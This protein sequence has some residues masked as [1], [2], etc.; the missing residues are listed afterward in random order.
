MKEYLLKAKFQF[1]FFFLYAL[2]SNLFCKDIYEEAINDNIIQKQIIQEDSKNDIIDY[3]L[4]PGKVYNLKLYKLKTANIRFLNIKNGDNYVIHFYPLECKIYLTD[5]NDNIDN[6]YKISNYDYDAFY[7]LITGNRTFKVKPLINLI[8]EEINNIT[9]PLIINSVK[10][11]NNSQIPELILNEKEPVLFFFKDKIT[12]L[13]LIYNHNKSENPIIIS[14]F[15]KEKARFRIEC[16][17]GKEKI[18]KI[19]YYKETLLIKPNS[20]N[21]QYNILITRI[22]QVNSTMIIKISGNNSSS[23]YL[24]N[25]ILNL[26]LI[27]KNELCQYYYMKI[28]KGQE[29]EIILNNKRLNG[30]L[31]SK[32]INKNDA[33]IIPNSELFPEC[34]KNI[35][36]PKE[37]LQYDEY[38]KI[39]SF[40]S[41]NTK[42]CEVNCYLL[43]TYYSEQHNYLNITGNEYTLL[44][45]VWDEEDFIS[46]V[47]NIP[48][49]EFIF[50]L[51][52]D[53]TINVHYYCVYIP[54]ETDNI[55]VE[56]FGENI[57]SYAKKGI[58]K[59]NVFKT[60][61]NTIQLNKK[62][63]EKLIINLNKKDLGLNSFKGQYI[64]LAFKR[65][66]N[67]NKFSYYHFRI[68]QPNNNNIIIYPVDTNKDGLCETKKIDGNNSCFFL[69][70]NEYQELSNNIVFFGQGQDEVSSVIY[71]LNISDDYSIELEN[72]ELNKN[73]ERAYG[74]IKYEGG[75]EDSKFALIK[76]MSNYYENITFV[77]N[78]FHIN[79]LN[80]IF[81]IYSYQL[82]FLEDNTKITFNIN[83]NISNKYRV[84]INNIG[85][86]GYLKSNDTD[87]N[88]DNINLEGRKEIY[89]F[90]FY[91]E[92]QIRNISL[93]SKRNLAFITKM[94][95][96]ITYDFM[97]ELDCQYNKRVIVNKVNKDK[98][99]IIYYIKDI[100][101]EGMD[102][103]IHFTFQNDSVNNNDFIIK[104]GFIDYHVFNDIENKDDVAHYLHSSFYGI[105]DP[106]IN[107]GLIV[108]DKEFSEENKN[109]EIINK[110]NDEYSF[111]L[112]DKNKN[113]NN[114]IN[115]FAYEIN[116]IPKND[117]KTFLIENEYTQSSFNLTNKESLGQKYFIEKSRVRNISF[118]LELSSNYKNVYIEFNN[119]TK[120]YNKAIFGGVKQ[121][122]LFLSSN[123]DN[124]YSFSV[125]VENRNRI[126][127]DPKF[128]VN[129][130]FIFYLEKR[131]INIENFINNFYL[132]TSNEFKAPTKDITEIE[133]IIKNKI[134]EKD[135]NNLT[136]F[137][138]LRYI[139]QKNIIENEIINTIAPIVSEMQYLSEIK[140]KDINKELTYK[141]DFDTEQNYL[142]SLIIK[143]V[144]ESESVKDEK[145]YSIPLSFDTKKGKLIRNIISIILISLGIAI[146]IILL[147]IIFCIRRKKKSRSHG[148]KLKTF[149]FTED[150]SN[151]RLTEIEADKSKDD[152]ENENENTFI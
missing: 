26:G 129:I 55:T 95:Y 50:G 6:I 67:E 27:P 53:K 24:Q 107:T 148:G 69:L 34:N 4:T 10:I 117:S 60:T 126:I 101:Y 83:Q 63:E 122:Y 59:I 65:V 97:D 42:E 111:I 142:I 134:K 128:S 35:N 143:I 138:Y 2:I 96:Q 11:S 149:S 132:S 32:I 144:N 123:E 41:S 137:Y 88:K 76:I 62:L 113:N 19:I 109:N 121:Y 36:L 141:K 74:Y 61:E 45:R 105:Y 125:I 56:I 12:N 85:G 40:N 151:L 127:K 91:N 73:N 93:F 71:C 15:I 92:I 108:F 100:K 38:N 21:T 28:Y 115:E 87:E 64:S 147:I 130:N 3:E 112:I 25:N 33:D 1:K 80:Q 23:F 52:D 140:T 118:Y 14:F 47:V 119:K 13:R 44:T 90:S 86:L 39:L 102:I 103:N 30:V 146:I 77:S 7:S 99:P 79:E 135:Y 22:D 94:E 18:N 29:G 16:N 110:Y 145:Y 54:E 106:I 152:D 49:N 68:L 136:Y 70:K 58:K 31:I 43:I 120:V 84:F 82:F 75:C 104:G 46:Q 89:S 124:D 81:D 98:F 20:S 133:L 5:S 66:N 48:L 57:I 150:F 139:N 114:N 51:I 116:V 78:F 131:Y 8:K 9:Y 72:L 37:Y 17:D